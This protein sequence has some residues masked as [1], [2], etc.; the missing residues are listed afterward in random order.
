MTSRRRT[1]LEVL[2]EYAHRRHWV[3]QYH[4]EAKTE[5]GW[6]QYQGRRWDGFH[7]QAVL[8]MVSYSFLVWVE[9]RSRG[10]RQGPGG[11]GPLFPPRP[12]RRRLS[13]PEVHRRVSEWLR[14]TAIRE[15]LAL[16]LLGRYFSPKLQL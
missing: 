15:L 13:L 9:A 6:D 1:P 11:P 5:L 12:D 7:R 2:V 4:E 10:Q 16:G 8:V 3:E 14:Q